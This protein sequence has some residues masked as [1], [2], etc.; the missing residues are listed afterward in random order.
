M[1]PKED[2]LNF[3]VDIFIGSLSEIRGQEG[4]RRTFRIP[5]QKHG[6]HSH[7]LHHG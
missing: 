5:D 2:I 4:T 1:D 3:F 6:E 7:S